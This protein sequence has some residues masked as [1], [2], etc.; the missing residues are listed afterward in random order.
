[1]LWSCWC[2]RWVTNVSDQS[3]LGVRVSNVRQSFDAYLA[4]K[5]RAS[6]S[7]Y[8]MLNDFV[9]KLSDLENMLLPRKWSR[10]FYRK[11]FW[12]PSRCSK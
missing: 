1:M 12:Y 9:S 8:E 6:Q 11:I 4:D 2:N 5:T 10:C 7:D 3:G